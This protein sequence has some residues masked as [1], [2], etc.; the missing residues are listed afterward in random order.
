MFLSLRD[1]KVRAGDFQILKS[2]NFSLLPGAIFNFYGP[3]GIGKTRL[4]K[5][6]AYC[7]EK[8]G[9]I[10]FNDR[11]KL[12]SDSTYIGLESS[13]YKDFTVRDNLQFMG[14]LNDN[15]IALLPAIHVF[16]LESCLDVKYQ[17]LSTGW[18]RKVVF[19]NLLFSQS[20]VWLIDEPFSSLDE[21]SKKRFEEV[22]LSKAANGGIILITNQVKCDNA[23]IYNFSL[24]PFA[25]NTES[26]N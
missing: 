13:L 22:I 2:L 5:T 6:I 26:N 11:S 4:L 23:E 9:S 20:P 18:K 16:D 24:L 10:I 7:E 25:N 14:R 12:V 21:S 3:N 19:A 1:L 8:D 15:E 17:D